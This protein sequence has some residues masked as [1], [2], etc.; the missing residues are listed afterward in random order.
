M[1]RSP[2]SNA[3]LAGK[4]GAHLLSATQ[5]AKPTMLKQVVDFQDRKQFNND[6]YPGSI[7]TDEIDTSNGYIFIGEP[8]A[9]EVLYNGAFGGE[10]VARINKRDFDLGVTVYELRPE[11]KYF[12]LSYTIHRAS[13]AQAPSRRMLLTPGKLERIPL[14]MTK[15]VSKRLSKGSR[16]VVYLNVNK[17]PFSQLNYGTGKDVSDETI[18]DAKEKLKVEW[19]NRSYITAPILRLV[20]P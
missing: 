16:L 1:R 10:I 18:A 11:G 15:L 3:P 7:V 5:P 13:Y 20:P 9:E 6:Y 2:A 14:G 19:S 8:F 17:N 12:H 4:H